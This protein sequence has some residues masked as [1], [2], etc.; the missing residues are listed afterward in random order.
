MAQV[1]VLRAK[2]LYTHRS[3]L[4][5][6]PN[7]SQRVCDNININREGLFELR[8]GLPTDTDM[9]GS[10]SSRLNKE[11]D[12]NNRLLGHYSTT[13]TRKNT[14]GSYTDYTGS[15]TVSDSDYKLNSAQANRN[16]YVSPDEGV[17]KLD[18]VTGIFRE[19]G[20]PR[21]LD[22]RLE[23]TTTTGVVLPV[24][25]AVGYKILWQYTDA[26]D[27]LITG[28]DNVTVTV[29]NPATNT[30]TRNVT[31]TIPIP[32]T[33]DNTW[34]YQIYRS[35][36]AADA[37]SVPPGDLQLVFENVVTSAQITAGVVVHTD[38]TLEI[39]R[40]ATIYT[41]STQEGA[42][43]ANTQP[44]RA[45]ALGMFKNHLFYG[46]TVSRH[47]R[48]FSFIT[49]GG[50]GFVLADTISLTDSSG[51]I[52]YTGA[53]AENATSR[54][55]EVFTTGNAAENLENTAR[56]LVF[57]INTDPNNSRYYAYYISGF[58][59][60]PGRILLEKRIL[61]N[62]AFTITS[63]RGTAFNPSLAGSGL[64]S[65]ND[66]LVNGLA[67][68]KLN[69][70]EA[71]P[72][73]RRIRVGSGNQRILALQALRDSLYIFKEDGIF[74]LTGDDV[75]N[76]RIEELDLTAILIAPETVQTLQNKIYCLTDQGI[77][78]VTDTGVRILSRRIE[79]QIN[80]L[81]TRQD[82]LRQRNFAVSYESD[83]KYIYFSI[84]SL[85]EIF[86]SQ[87]HVYDTITDTWTRWTVPATS[88]IVFNDRLI[89]GSS[90]SN[91]IRT[92]R[93]SL[94]AADFADDE[95]S[96]TIDTIDGTAITVTN[97]TV[98]PIV[99]GDAITLANGGYVHVTAITGNNITV[100][101][102]LVAS[103]LGSAVVSKAIP[104]EIEWN[105]I[106]AGN[107]GISKQFQE[108]T[109]RFRRPFQL[110][111]EVDFETDIDASLTPTTIA[112][113]ELQGGWGQFSWGQVNWG[114]E[115]SQHVAKRTY[116][117]RDKQRANLIL[118]N[119]KHIVAFDKFQLNGFIIAYRPISLRTVR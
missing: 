35:G 113:D 87:A 17:Q 48:I 61:D 36:Q 58:S 43:A 119:L 95:F 59:S 101:N 4:T 75:E 104:V 18:S 31:L 19:A 106:D 99:V 108:I 46:N 109:Y 53:A 74:R 26:N 103:D 91:T 33:V 67:F 8:R 117:P 15:F 89:L 98:I 60:L 56:S 64:V 22:P 45:A 88:G 83:R 73:A 24:N 80:T 11:Y 27:N 16:F 77:V 72:L 29:A 10:S 118:P 28:A 57:I 82:L 81:F 65:T 78:T 111:I 100:N 105:A 71:V 6:V 84:A 85:G 39:S 112:G 90:T 110:S 49:V 102:D 13:M 66:V 68:S 37:T 92:E 115:S 7:S 76:F 30:T 3:E 69:E 47:N 38:T 70:P 96:I 114:G 62:D 94:D 23:L 55:F 97:T 12:F 63:S 51:A 1:E 32:D 42:S 34:T 79:D 2:G 20:A 5:E 50:S 52:T 25:T 40:G 54:Q 116:I 107:P 9:F 14:D 21:A 86:P 93:K 41:A 44:P